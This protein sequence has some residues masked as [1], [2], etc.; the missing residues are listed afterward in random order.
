MAK[1]IL[2]VLCLIT[3][4][5][6]SSYAFAHSESITLKPGQ[7]VQLYV[8]SN[9]SSD[10]PGDT[11]HGWT[12]ASGSAASW[13]TPNHVDFGDQQS[14]EHNKVN[15]MLKV[16]DSQ[17]PGSYEVLWTTSCTSN[18]D[19]CTGSVHTVS[20][21][22]E[23]ELQPVKDFQFSVVVP[24]FEKIQQDSQRTI[25]VRTEII[26]GEPEPVSLSTTTWQE[27]LGIYGWFEP[28]VVTPQ[29]SATLIVKTSCKTPPDNYQ[30]YVNGVAASGASSTDIVTVTVEPNTKCGQLQ[31]TSQTAQSSFGTLQVSSPV[32]SSSKYSPG[33]IQVSGTVT[34]I[35]RGMPLVLE[36][37]K[38]DNSVESQGIIISK[39]GNFDV[40]V[41]IKGDWPKGTYTVT[42][43]YGPNEIGTVAFQVSDPTTTPGVIKYQDKQYGFTINYPA[44]WQK[45]TTFEK[46]PDKPNRLTLA[47]FV[48]P[49]QDGLFLVGLAQDDPYFRGLDEQQLLE[50]IKQELIDY[51]HTDCS[52][53][54][55]LSS[56]VDTHANGYKM[57]YVT[58]TSVLVTNGNTVSPLFAYAIIPD[59]KDFWLISTIFFNPDTFDS[60]VTDMT[61][62][63]QSFTISNFEGISPALSEP[64]L[65]LSIPKWIKNNA[66][67]WADG[68][69]TDDEFIRGIEHLINQGIIIIPQVEPST[70]PSKQIPIWFKN[71]VKWWA[72]GQTQDS[73]FINGVQY[74][75]KN[76]L[77]KVTKQTPAPTP[78]P[79]TK[80]TPTPETKQTPTPETKQTPAP[81]P[82]PQGLTGTYQGTA[83]WTASFEYYSPVKGLYTETCWY[84]GNVLINLTQNG[85]DVGGS[86]QVSNQEATADYDLSLCQQGFTLE[87]VV[88]GVVF[89]S[90][91]SG[92]VGVLNVD[93]QFTSDML[94]GNVFGDLGGVV[95]I[96]GEFTS[97]RVS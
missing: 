5:S 26:K 67:W 54:E 43:T 18:A 15:Y 37:K 51:C 91:F 28:S 41:A 81:A 71:T 31:S 57:Y 97:S 19:Y 24:V 32:I 23:P 39:D 38:P 6:C 70:S 47:T 10:L 74:L 68:M 96:S 88:D 72:E 13:V 22:V 64:A 58:F 87:G 85:N 34:S 92:T 65:S 66:K 44:T 56:E 8:D 84:T 16:P 95:A 55:F 94:R 42:A 12:D 62:M 9:P 40:P 93:A 4:F 45:N 76:N 90:G 78:F 33:V 46:D 48:S 49:K 61:N 82:K 75:V 21:T 3:V 25:T 52:D 36:I 2:G 53:I 20:I 83:K 14:G 17:E 50:A 80:Q 79:E 77:I 1:I 69:L 35:S 73:D 59:G 63:S 86:A 29:N 89:G 7:E 60:L 27:S 30:F 11:I